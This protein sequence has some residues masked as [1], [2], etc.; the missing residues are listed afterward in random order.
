M[1][2]DDYTRTYAGSEGTDAQCDAVLDALG[3]VEDPAGL[4][5]AEGNGWGCY[6]TTRDEDG[7]RRFRDVAPTNPSRRRGIVQSACACR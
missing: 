4:A 6:V 7:H 3:A 2:Y 1:T 5:Q